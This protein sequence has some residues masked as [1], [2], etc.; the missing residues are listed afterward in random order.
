MYASWTNGY[1]TNDY[2]QMTT[3]TNYYMKDSTFPIL[4]VNSLLIFK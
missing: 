1:K 4:D 3:W 2:G